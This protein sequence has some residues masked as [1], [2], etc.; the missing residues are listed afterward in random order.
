MK[1]QS[2]NQIKM[3][4]IERMKAMQATYLRAKESGQVKIKTYYAPV[5][6]QKSVLPK[7]D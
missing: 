4:K 2:T 6:S 5:T 7:S 1:S 3:N